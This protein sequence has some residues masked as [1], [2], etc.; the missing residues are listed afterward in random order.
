MVPAYGHDPRQKLRDRRSLDPVS[1]MRPQNRSRYVLA[2]QKTQTIT[3]EK[4]GPS[5]MTNDRRGPPMYSQQR[6]F[7]PE[8]RPGEIWLANVEP[9]VFNSIGWQS[10]R[11][12]IKSYDSFGFLLKGGTKRPVMVNQ[13][14]IEAAGV[15]IPT[16]GAM[17]LRLRRFGMV[18]NTEAISNPT[19]SASSKIRSAISSAFIVMIIFAVLLITALAGSGIK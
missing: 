17:E 9:D 10:K 7:H 3:L 14:E 16:L 19:P 12:G 2:A 8:A 4:P 18:F 13:A 15:Q 5:P 6:F 1:D 11:L